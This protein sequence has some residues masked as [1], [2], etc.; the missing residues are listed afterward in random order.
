MSLQ[1]GKSTGWDEGAIRVTVNIASSHGKPM[2]VLQHGRSLK[3]L[4]HNIHEPI[5]P[6]IV[7]KGLRVT[8]T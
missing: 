3:A 4:H 8:F 1:Q 6:R 5:E 2:R 7:T